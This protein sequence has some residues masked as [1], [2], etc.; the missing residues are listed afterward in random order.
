MNKLI[1]IINVIAWSGFWAFG[2]LALTAEGLSSKQLTVAAFLAFAGFITG[3]V[4]YLRLVR[5]A[6]ASGYARKSN[7]LD[8]TVRNRA[9]SQGSI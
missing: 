5:A 2:Y 4:A 1:A 9:Q 6:E 8:A 3:M 7:Q